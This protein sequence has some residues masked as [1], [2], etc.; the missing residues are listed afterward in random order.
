[1]AMI[2]PRALIAAGDVSTLDEDV[3]AAF[4]AERRWYGSR[5]QDVAHARV[6]TA[7]PVSDDPPLA[8][9]LVQVGFHS[10]AHEVY[11]LMLGLRSPDDS[12]DT[13]VWSVGEEEIFEAFDDPRDLQVI[14]AHIRGSMTFG[15]ESGVQFR[16][17]VGADRFDPLPGHPR[18][19]GH[20]QTNTSVV[21]DDRMILKCYRRLEPGINPEL[22][23]LRFLTAHDFEHTPLLLGWFAHTG[24][25]L[26]TTLGVVQH[27]LADAQDGWEFV[28]AALRD[29]RGDEVLP[30]LG[31]LGAVT[32]QLHA[33]LA[34]ERTDPAFLPEEVSPEGL[35]LMSAALDELTTE[36]FAG[37]P[38]S[39]TLA[40]IAGR[41]D[42]IRERLR[43]V[44][45]SIGLGRKIRVHGDLHLGQALLSDDEWHLIDFEGEPAR[46]A[47]ERR[48]KRSPLRDIAGLVRSL[49]YAVGAARL[50]HNVEVPD[51][52][53]PSA[54][55]AVLDGYFAVVEPTGLLP[56]TAAM[57]DEVLG[58]YELEKAVYELRYEIAHRPDWAAIPVAAI[59]SLLGRSE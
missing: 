43:G 36:V 16:S 32:G 59:E 28:L 56:P 17:A 8:I 55:A 9:A 5:Q 50:H 38:D 21:F 58:L 33:T 57:T 30:D 34:S 41:A 23:V 48:R 3:L 45:K 20:E 52:W 11:Q 12:A 19:A 6:V 40:P 7:V 2:D 44:S 42:D 26:D 49:D 35:A 10:G 25:P 18:P 47:N 13:T 37:L 14:L 51:V 53:L 1:M 27:Y 4:V 24:P 29:G 31:R 39:P 15:D 22:E 54:R 46:P